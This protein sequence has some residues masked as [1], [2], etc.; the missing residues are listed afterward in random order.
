MAPVKGSLVI[1][2][3]S[4]GNHCFSRVYLQ[5]AV[6]HSCTVVHFTGRL[7]VTILGKGRC[8]LSIVKSNTISCVSRDI[9][10]FLGCIVHPYFELLYTYIYI[11][12]EVDENLVQK[13]ENAFHPVQRDLFYYLRAYMI[14]E[15]FKLS[16]LIS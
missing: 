9:L 5:V 7:V 13:D 10:I 11:Y 3:H 1:S 6:T 12:N 16:L 2:V 15:L 4:S 14:L 8:L